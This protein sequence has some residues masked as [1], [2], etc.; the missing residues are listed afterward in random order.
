M[1]QLKDN[2][3]TYPDSKISDLN[4]DNYKAQFT[5][6]QIKLIQLCKE[7]SVKEIEK[8]FNKNTKKPLSLNKLLIDNRISLLI[9]QKTTRIISEFIKI[10][11]SESQYLCHH[12][13]RDD[14][15]QKYRLELNANPLQ[16]DLHFSQTESGI[17][18]RLQ[19]N[20]ANSEV[21]LYGK[22]LT[23]Y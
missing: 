6:L 12:I 18:Y 15:T 13:S 21:K 2:T 16:A 7:L 11:I 19:L 4:F 22:T 23:S 5:S 14:Q 9:H 10:C 20:A 1:V 3:L 8:Y 17:E